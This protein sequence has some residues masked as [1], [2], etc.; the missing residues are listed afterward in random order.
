MFIDEKLSKNDFVTTKVIIVE[1][2]LI[3]DLKVNMFINTNIITLQRLC[4]NLNKR[5]L[6]IKTC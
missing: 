2:H 4:I 5:V 3:N 1:A 6:I